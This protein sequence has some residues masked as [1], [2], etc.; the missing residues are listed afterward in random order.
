[1]AQF[2]VYLNPNSLTNDQTPYLLDIQ[3]NIL[4]DLKT[5]V[6][7]PINRRVKPIKHLNPTLKINGENFTLSTAELAAVPISS[8]GN[9][10]CSLENDRGM[11]I[12]AI[13][14]ML[15]GF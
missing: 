5:R 1:M 8:L 13:D 12:S 6:V 7:I 14:F 15:T 2:D 4:K 11:I 10:V 3:H 9:Y